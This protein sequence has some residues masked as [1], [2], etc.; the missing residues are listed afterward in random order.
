MGE[1]INQELHQFVHDMKNELA[2]VRGALQCLE[3]EPGKKSY[4][5]LAY[6]HLDKMNQRLM[7]QLEKEKDKTNTL[8]PVE[9]ERLMDEVLADFIPLLIKQNTQVQVSYLEDDA[10][11]LADKEELKSCFAN[12]VKNAL[13]AR[14]SCIF[15][16][17]KSREDR[18]CITIEDNGEGI[19][20]D[21]LGCIF[22]PYVTTKQ[23]GSGIG[24]YSVKKRIAGWNGEIHVESEKSRG[25]RF[26]LSFP[27]IKD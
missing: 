8:K 4:F 25:T 18:V 15:I 11:F 3:N 21:M 20:Q 2:L 5:D 13:E 6:R 7:E 10:R 1:Q 17:V 26:L 16:A 23:E 22:E 19:S 14:A 27:K 9:P 24:L 12:L